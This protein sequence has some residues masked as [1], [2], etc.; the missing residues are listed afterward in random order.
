MKK[1]SLL[2]GSAALLVACG[3]NHSHETVSLTNEIDSVSYSLGANMAT[4]IAK[5]FSEAN[6]EAFVQ[7]FRDVLD[8][9][10]MMIS[11]D[12]LQGVLQPFFQKKQE[13]AMKKTTRRSRT[14]SS[15][16]IWRC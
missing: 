12:E 14:S 15:S 9:A 5:D 2:V 1:I 10:D 7:G 16:T 8:S 13:E 11:T 6:T 4:N 3:G